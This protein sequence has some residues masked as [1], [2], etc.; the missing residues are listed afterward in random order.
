MNR[1]FHKLCSGEYEAKN[2]IK[3][4]KKDFREKIS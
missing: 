2:I 1:K 4:A 3:Y